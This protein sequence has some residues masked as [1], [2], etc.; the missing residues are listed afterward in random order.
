MEELTKNNI[1]NITELECIL[2]FTKMGY[3][4]SLPYGGQARYDFIAE[5]NGKFLRIQVKT[6]TDKKDYLEF[7]CTNSHYV[8]GHHIHTKYSSDEIDYFATTCR[9]QC[10]IVPITECSAGKRLRFTTPRNNQTKGISF[11]KDYTLE[12]VSKIL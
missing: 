8:K 4:V 9:G 11:A 1:G 10:F 3:Q 6:S 2:A 7:S 12:E 5:K